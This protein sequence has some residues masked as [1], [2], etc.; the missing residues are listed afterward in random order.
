MDRQCWHAKGRVCAVKTW[1]ARPARRSSESSADFL[2]TWAWLANEIIT[3]T[4]RSPVL[5]LSPSLTPERAW[6]S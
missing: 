4:H 1:K 5:F 6:Q 2:S 3:D